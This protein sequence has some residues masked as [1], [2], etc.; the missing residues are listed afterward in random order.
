MPEPVICLK[1]YPLMLKMLRK[2][3]FS[4]KNCANFGE[5][6]QKSNIENRFSCSCDQKEDTT[7]K[8]WKMLNL[9]RFLVLFVLCKTL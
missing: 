9:L 7:T 3:K 5:V 8:I 2:L 1:I 6:M 4:K